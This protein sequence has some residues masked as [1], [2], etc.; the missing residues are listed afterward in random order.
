[1]LVFSLHAAPG[2]YVTGD[3]CGIL[4][5]LSVSIDPTCGL[6]LIAFEREQGQA[7]MVHPAEHSIQSRLI[8][9]RPME[10]GCAVRVVRD[11]QPLKP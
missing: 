8:L 2:W 6:T 7:Q 10:V 4:A 11:L 9:E 3:H 1:M 5:G